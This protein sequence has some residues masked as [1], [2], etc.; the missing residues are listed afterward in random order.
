MTQTKK[1][2]FGTQ[3]GLNG[4]I[5]AHKSKGWMVDSTAVI[6]RGLASKLYTYIAF[7]SRVR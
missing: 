5:Q 4:A 3:R 7:L 2:V 1:L 6:P